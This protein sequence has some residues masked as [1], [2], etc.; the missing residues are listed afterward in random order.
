MGWRG[1]RG[2]DNAGH[3][4]Q[5]FGNWL[6][7]WQNRRDDDDCAIGRGKPGKG[8]DGS[9][10]SGGGR[11][12]GSDGSG[13]GADSKK[14]HDR[15]GGDV[16]DRGHD[17]HGNGKGKGHDKNGSGG[18][19]D[20]CG[21]GDYLC[22]GTAPTFLE[23]S[24]EE[25]AADPEVVDLASPFG[26]D[27]ANT[28]YEIVDGADKDRFVVDPETG[29]LS[30]AEGQ[31]P[32]F[33]EGGDN[34]YEVVVRTTNELNPCECVQN[35]FVIEVVDGEITSGGGTADPNFINLPANDPAA[36]LP[37]F[38]I[39][40]TV[41]SITLEAEDEDSLAD[42]LV[43]SII[44][45]DARA[46]SE[47]SDAF[48]INADTGVITFLEPLTATDSFDGDSKYEIDVR[49]EDEDGGFDEISVI[50]QPILSS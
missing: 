45:N 30:F 24:D 6:N 31:V 46:A 12:R 1:F 8:S 21:G 27:D 48:S 11:G 18:S 16:V 10:G 13:G 17:L 38:L 40:S 2:E 35:R 36:G 33:T 5:G 49:V 41:T 25:L 44:D 23:F 39:Q 15:D 20:D 37:R 43:F 47:D 9:G 50:I 22:G 7:N 32:E 29:E 14:G 34:T 4:H 26:T 19:D 42:S 28:L 3:N